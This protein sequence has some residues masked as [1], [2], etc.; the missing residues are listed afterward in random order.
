MM[1]LISCEN[2]AVVLDANKVG[3]PSES[4]K[5]LD[6]GSVDENNFTWDGDDYVPFVK[7]P[8]CNEKIIK[9]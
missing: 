8:V 3:F 4:R 1:N 5:Y 7:C 2:C 9:E 6:D